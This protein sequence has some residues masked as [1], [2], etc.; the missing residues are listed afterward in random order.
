MGPGSY[1]THNYN[2]I[3][4]D[5]KKGIGFGT[6]KR[7]PLSDTENVP[8]PGNYKHQIYKTTQKSGYT[9]PKAANKDKATEEGGRHYNIK[10]TIPATAKYALP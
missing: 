3:K 2:A 1:N 9:I 4:A 10:S 8:G 6:S 7:K 5:K